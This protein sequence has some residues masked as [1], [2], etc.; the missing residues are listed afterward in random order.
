[1]VTGKYKRKPTNSK[2]NLLMEYFARDGYRTKEL[3]KI[4]F[5]S[6]DL[7]KEELLNSVAS[8]RSP[9]L[10][11]ADFGAKKLDGKITIIY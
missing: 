1:M 3:S 7:F 2:E 6:F 8:G 11:I 9:F 5:E 4:N 10:L